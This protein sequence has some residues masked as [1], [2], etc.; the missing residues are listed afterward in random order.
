MFI[1][2]VLTEPASKIL[3][4]VFEQVCYGSFK[5]IVEDEPLYSC[6]VPDVYTWEPAHSNIGIR[7]RSVF[8]RPLYWKVGTLQGLGSTK[9]DSAK[10]L[11]KQMV[12]GGM[13]GGLCVLEPQKYQDR[14][15]VALGGIYRSVQRKD[16]LHDHNDPRLVNFQTLE[17]NPIR[18]FERGSLD[19]DHCHL[20]VGDK[21]VLQ[22]GK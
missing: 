2:N 9:E 16:S 17:F 11:L 18:G 21:I 7:I 14:I 4:S 6:V 8:N 12:E 22:P 5:N 10:S 19:G 3:T 15:P 20:W 13:H 1:M